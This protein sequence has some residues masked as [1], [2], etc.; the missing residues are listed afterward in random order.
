M[1]RA[2]SRLA[3]AICLATGALSPADAAERIV[4][5][6]QDALISAL[7]NAQAGD[8]LRL[9]PGTHQGPI[10]IDRA[11]TLLGGG[12]AAIKGP[13]TGSVIT[14]DAPD[15]TVSG[16][17]L[18]GSGLSQ[19]TL[20]AG[21]KLT[22][23]ADRAIVRD[24]R[25]LD[26]LVGVDVHGPDDAHVSNNLIE[27]RRD[28]RPN[29]RGNGI[30]VWN[31]PGLIAEHNTIRFGRDGIFVNTSARNVFRNNRI[32]NVRFAI[33]YMHGNDGEISG[34]VSTGNTIGYALMFSDRLVIKNNVSLGDSN[35][36]LML[37]YANN[38]EIT[39]NLVRAGGEKCLFMYNA[40]KNKVEGNRFEACPIGI[41][42]TA[43]SARNNFVGNAFVGNQSQ[44]KYVGSRDLDWSANGRGNYW[45]DHAA[46]DANGD[47]IADTVFRPNDMVDQILWTQPAAKLLIGSPAVQLL[48]WTQSQ[49]PTLLPGGIVDTAP[50]MHAPTLSTPQAGVQG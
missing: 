33:H 1:K 30:Y 41:H 25:M 37:N 29:E 17:T 39:G 31:A 26:N 42:F 21:V 13:G 9:A 35:H 19:K 47:G 43:G 18:T 2:L 40:N 16:L 20:D 36:G 24:N 15:V 3:L 22:K 48:R 10:V 49:F 7:E 6:G 50:L 32:E 27:G 46:F 44:V 38:A 4:L 12:L 14:V 11:L 23:K 45:S 28:L 8:I 34:N 5:A